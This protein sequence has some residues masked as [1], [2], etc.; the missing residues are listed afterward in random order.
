MAASTYNQGGLTQWEY[1]PLPGSNLRSSPSP[2]KM[3][4]DALIE[5]LY[6]TN[7]CLQVNA[8]NPKNLMSAALL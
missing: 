8:G 6:H 7:M 5:S 2:S 4:G 3:C 1:L